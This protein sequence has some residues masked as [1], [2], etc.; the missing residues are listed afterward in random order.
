MNEL[1]K[2]EL[3][4]LAEE[5]GK[6]GDNWYDSRSMAGFP[7]FQEDQDFVIAASPSAV[8]A[9]L[10]ECE[11]GEQWRN[12]ALQCDMH[13]MQAMALIRMVA[14][15]I[16]SSSQCFEFAARPP[17]PGHEIIDRMSKAEAERDAALAELEAYKSQLRALIHISDAT[18]WERHTCGEIAKA[19]KLL[20]GKE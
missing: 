14:S 5:C 13:R 20:E 2:A 3:R 9:L 6:H 11:S 15:G 10:D 4:R 19:R 18:N 17:I 16:A 1:N 7:E 8:L 12:F